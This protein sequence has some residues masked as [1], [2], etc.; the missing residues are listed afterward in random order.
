MLYSLVSITVV[1]F[2]SCCFCINLINMDLLSYYYFNNVLDNNTSSMKMNKFSTH[3]K[4]FIMQYLFIIYL[5]EYVIQGGF[6][7]LVL[8]NFHAA[9]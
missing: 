8:S 9:T 1:M 3:T 4:D 2:Q 5:F 7:C 6:L